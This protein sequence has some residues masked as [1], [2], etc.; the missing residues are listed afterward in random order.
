MADMLEQMAQG[1]GEGPLSYEEWERLY[2]SGQLEEQPAQEEITEPVEQGEFIKGVNRGWHSSKAMLY[3]SAMLLG[4]ATDSEYLKQLGLE[5]YIEEM[6]EAQ[7]YAASVQNIED[8]SSYGEAADWFVGTMGELAPSAAETI[9]SAIVGGGI[10]GAVG[11][12]LIKKASKEAVEKLMAK[13][14]TK[15]VAEQ[16][17][18]RA[19]GKKV[20]SAAG[21]HGFVWALESGGMFAEDV[22]DG[23]W[24]TANPTSAAAFGALSSAA[25]AFGGE[26]MLIRKYLGPAGE[27]IAK[28]AAKEGSERTRAQVMKHLGV[29]V[30]KGIASEGTTEGFQEMMGI[31]NS[32]YTNGRDLTSEISD[33]EWSALINASAKG[34]AGGF[35]FGTLTGLK[36]EHAGAADRDDSPSAEQGAVAI[37]ESLS[38]IDNDIDSALLSGDSEKVVATKQKKKELKAAKEQQK[39]VVEAEERQVQ[40]LATDLLNFS[41]LQIEEQEKI[42]T[43]TEVLT[44]LNTEREA[45]LKEISALTQETIFNTEVDDKTRSDNQQKVRNAQHKVG[46]IDRLMELND[47]YGE[48]LP[49][50]DGTSL[51]A[52]NPT[53]AQRE[54]VET[55]R[56]AVEEAKAKQQ[57]EQ[58]TREQRAEQVSQAV[59]REQ[60]AN[61]VAREVRSRL[62][63]RAQLKG[64]R[65]AIT[66]EAQSKLDE[67]MALRQ[68]TEEEAVEE[69]G[70]IADTLIEEAAERTKTPFE[71]TPLIEGRTLEEAAEGGLI[72]RPVQPT[73]PTIEVRDE[74]APVGEEVVPVKPA[75]QLV[76]PTGAP[77]LADI[78]QKSLEAKRPKKKVF[79]KPTPKPLIEKVE[80]P[81]KKQLPKTPKVVGTKSGKPFKTEAAAKGAI[82]KLGKGKSFD[83]KVDKME[84]GYGIRKKTQRE[85]DLSPKMRK[86]SSHN[87]KD[88]KW[89]RTR[90]NTYFLQ[91]KDGNDLARVEYET[92][93][94][95]VVVRDI[96]V[97]EQGK[98]YG[99]AVIDKLIS[100][101]ETVYTGKKGDKI[102]TDATHMISRIKKDKRYK[103]KESGEAAALGTKGS[104][105][106][107]PAFLPKSHFS[108]TS[109]TPKFSQKKLTKVGAE[110]RQ[111]AVAR[112]VDSVTANLPAVTEDR[113]RVGVLKSPAELR[114]TGNALDMQLYNQL[115][116]GGNLDALGVFHGDII[117]LFSNNMDG[118]IKEVADTVVHELRHFSVS[119]L[120][121][122]DLKNLFKAFAKQ[123]KAKFEKILKD[124]GLEINEEN[125]LVLSEEVLVES[126]L[127]GATTKWTERLL[128]AIKKWVRRVFGDLEV[129]DAEIRTWVKKLDK[130]LATSK[131][132]GDKSV[133]TQSAF[134][135]FFGDWEKSP[136]KASKIVDK[137]GEPLIVYHGSP[138]VRF[139]AFSIKASPT[140]NKGIY[141]T[142]DPA[143]ASNYATNPLFKKKVR[144]GVIPAY[145]NMRNPK[146]VDKS[147]IDKWRDR[148]KDTTFSMP[149][150]KY[151]TF[152]ITEEMVKALHKQGYDGIWN[153]VWDEVIVFNA[154]QIL[155]AFER[156]V[157]VKD[158]GVKPKTRSK[159]FMEAKRAVGTKDI[160]F[161]ESAKALGETVKTTG[162]NEIY[163]QMF[164]HTISIKNLLGERLHQKRRLLA[165]ADTV[166]EHSLINGR[167]KFNEETQW[168]EMEDVNTVDGPLTALETL[169]EY[170]DVFM[171]WMQAQSIKEVKATKGIKRDFYGVGKDEEYIRAIEA[172]A[173]NAIKAVGKDK[174]MNV[175]NTF[176]AFTQSKLDIGIATGNLDAE[177][178]EQ[179]R[180]NMY[181]PLAR[182]VEQNLVDDIS[183]LDPVQ[184]RSA[185][186][187]GIETLSRK[188]S[189]GMLADPLEAYI[190]NYKFMM[191]EAM[192]NQVWKENIAMML[193]QELASPV[194]KFK[195]NHQIVGVNVKGKVKYFQI[196]DAGLFE[197]LQE[198]PVPVK[199]ML[200]K[201]ISAPR[202]FFTKW[203]TRTPAFMIRNLIRDT[204]H[205]W[206]LMGD[207]VGIVEAWTDA[208]KSMVHVYR[209]HP[210]FRELMSMGGAF[211]EY[212]SAN[213]ISAKNIMNKSRHKIRNSKLVSWYLRLGVAAENAN[214]LAMY[215]RLKN[216]D[217]INAAFQAKDIMDFSAT[218][219]SAS[220]RSMILLL[221]FFNARLQGLGKIGRE[222]NKRERMAM[223]MR[224]SLLGLT[225]IYLG[226]M[227]EDEEEWHTMTDSE[228]FTSMHAWV[229][230]THFKI[231]L[232]F[233]LSILYTAPMAMGEVLRGNK[234]A[235][236]LWDLTKTYMNDTLAFNPVPQAIKPIVEDATNRDMF[237]DRPIV[238][239]WEKGIDPSEQFSPWTSH[240]VK[241]IAQ[242]MPDFMPDVMR[243]PKRLQHLLD[244]Y[245]STAAKL[246]YGLSDIMMEATG[247]SPARSSKDIQQNLL[248]ATGI[249]KLATR[250]VSRYT[251]K[252]QKVY[253]G[254]EEI[255][256]I[257]NTYAALKSRQNLAQARGYLQTH[258]KEIKLAKYYRGWLKGLKTLNTKSRLIEES[259]KLSAEQKYV[260]QQKIA[261]KKAI[262]FAKIYD[263]MVKAGVYKPS[264]KEE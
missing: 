150:T 49:E 29:E 264:R 6:E 195:A 44:T 208:F 3:G 221:P 192:R 251:N 86:K 144:P 239:H 194:K 121:G 205:T 34:A 42:P 105:T 236:M 79:E 170:K 28:D 87:V 10:G 83:Y 16:A 118:P 263:K 47:R 160:T 241:A 32:R 215:R 262:V 64:R 65:Q 253:A 97:E 218:G 51:Y 230:D 149:S 112:V 157:E 37:D 23:G 135:D 198:L 234:S 69:A 109:S 137:N 163:R 136:K 116:E 197:A 255:L 201:A 131:M 13:G 74:R 180:R 125:M 38:T 227:N 162:A 232:P 167:L 243:S 89:E 145:I 155:P 183:N 68:L 187:D 104:R 129:S 75:P 40:A 111:D 133:S 223:M 261:R 175:M 20:G 117:Y 193:K 219:R 247:I 106:K 248:N 238:G 202:R 142:T 143:L 128:A 124:Q 19:I 233:E 146:I 229:G 102:S 91:D 174:W 11:K 114:N 127:D 63:K 186:K 7:K 252:E 224:G 78:K 225:A 55:R 88:L 245:F 1:G 98:G 119:E 172:E 59:D 256:E 220:L 5:G 166:A 148:G 177:L 36:Q 214:R 66:A 217:K 250:E 48:L 80:G 139:D 216:A 94:D 231:P 15:E 103:V 24:A 173:A 199:G 228:K 17:V 254:M 188:G 26:A 130:N 92:V 165:N 43:K 260:E 190:A 203:V 107:K 99:Q 171:M 84:D 212:D 70:V 85:K 151:G 9:V 176:N 57:Q 154:E 246:S 179:W 140:N 2:M 210:D 178:V 161:T 115:K 41:P 196:E 244:G 81:R 222:W 101:N 235:D 46:E 25:E 62:D 259:K 185:V 138:D 126:Y 53:L 240:T 249:S 52:F 72:D 100:E 60:A 113:I 73:T 132:E 200:A 93:P 189:K 110:L 168:V 226:M 191:N 204:M 35:G 95:G 156:T 237:R 56:K 120:M 71:P 96:E 153:K 67:A 141:F 22:E 30:M 39:E 211:A 54:M 45:A 258:G 169:G 76:T 207:K 152:T 33:D 209:D 158:V 181:I 182:E 31:L 164:D 257:A 18:K 147:F 184:W 21:M 213:Q 4:K 122:K 206:V 27:K 159:A 58:S 61:I 8:I 14:A 12:T 82:K 123:N 108:I 50:E 134:K 242:A 77:L 90:G